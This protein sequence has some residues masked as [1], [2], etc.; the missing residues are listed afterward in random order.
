MRVERTTLNQSAA[1][2]LL[3][4]LARGERSDAGGF[5]QTLTESVSAAA[6]RRESGRRDDGI[7]DDLAQKKQ[8]AERTQRSP[9][10]RAEPRSESA[11]RAAAADSKANRRSDSAANQ[12]TAGQGQV[13]TQQ[14]ADEAPA[15]QATQAASAA[16]ANAAGEQTVTPTEISGGN[17]ATNAAAELAAGVHAQQQK[18]AAQVPTVAVAADT[19]PE[20]DLSA[21]LEIG[22][23]QV[24]SK[25]TQVR[26]TTIEAGLAGQAQQETEEQLPTAVSGP[27][28]DVAEAVEKRSQQTQPALLSARKVTV[29]GESAA[30]R[31]QAAGRHKS[32][33][34]IMLKP[35]AASAQQS[36]ARQALQS[37]GFQAMGMRADI[38][39]I[40][41]LAPAATMEVKGG[42][43]AEGIR[44]T[45]AG[46]GRV[47]DHQALLPERQEGTPRAEQ[48]E[49]IERITRVIRASLSRGGSRINLQLEPIELGKLRVH[50]Q[51]R[52]GE[53]TARFET[54][55]ETS[56]S[57]LQNGLNQLRESLASHG[58]RLVQA[59]VDANAGDAGDGTFADSGS[60][61]QAFGQASS[62][63]GH[64]EAHQTFEGHHQQQ[65]PPSAEEVELPL[66]AG[67]GTAPDRLNVIG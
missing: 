50:M 41:V 21:A 5:Q 33:D 36:E 20:V 60:S 10:E 12:Q 13:Q 18:L 23:E 53:L 66:M 17:A 49:Q 44:P 64:D 61:Q 42:E 54:Q 34:D 56:K 7:A 32:S 58:I 48:D 51:L 4:A 57:W 67:A 14:V 24:A 37:L 40:Q 38:V 3:A 19:E 62:D 39:N 11:P 59:S 47:Q 29:S 55:N 16:G 26:R 9:R 43:S 46:L 6:P 65:S 63:R 25:S 27:R 15:T 35:H 45:G 1:G 8:P 2:A 22:V 31:D 30:S 52:S 28:Q